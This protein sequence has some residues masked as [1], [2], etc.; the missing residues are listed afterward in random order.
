MAGR[1]KTAASGHRQPRIID[2]ERTRGTTITGL[3]RQGRRRSRWSPK[4]RLDACRLAASGRADAEVSDEVGALPDPRSTSH[5]P[6]RL[7]PAQTSPC[8]LRSPEAA[9]R[10]PD[11]PGGGKPGAAPSSLWGQC[12]PS[13]TGRSDRRSPRTP[14]RSRDRPVAEAVASGAGATKREQWCLFEVVSVELRCPRKVG[15]GRACP[16]RA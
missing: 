9:V 7:R 1:L 8:G 16:L 6:A 5:L 2:A 14:R 12:S 3:D 15:R 11:C 4:R 13:D 10:D